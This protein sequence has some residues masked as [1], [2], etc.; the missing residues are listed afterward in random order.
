MVNLSID[1]ILDAY[2]HDVNSSC[3][4]GTASADDSA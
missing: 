3:I 2:V 1:K 4:Y